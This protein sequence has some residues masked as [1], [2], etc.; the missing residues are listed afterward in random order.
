MNQKIE[1]TAIQTIIFCV[2]YITKMNPNKML[3]L[4]LFEYENFYFLR[5]VTASE[6]LILSSTSDVFV[7]DCPRSKRP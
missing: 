3:E 6:R 7:S 4:D 5:Y 2:E 1:K